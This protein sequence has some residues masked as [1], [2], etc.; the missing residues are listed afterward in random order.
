MED[1]GVDDARTQHGDADVVRQEVG[2]HGLRDAD[3]R[4]FRCGVDRHAGQGN[5]P[6][7]R[8]GVDEMPALAMGLDPVDEGHDAVDHTVVVDA[9][10]PVPVLVRHLVDGA[11]QDDARVVAHDVDV[12]EAFLRRVGRGH[13]S[14]AIGHVE[15]HGQEF[16]V[17]GLELA[18]HG[19]QGRLLD[20]GDHHLHAGVGERTRHGEPHAAC[21]AGDEC[22]LAG[23][24]A[25][26]CPLG[27]RVAAKPITV[28]A[29]RRCRCPDAT[30]PFA[31]LRSRRRLPRCRRANVRGHR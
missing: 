26:V 24:V 21:T 30:P 31:L 18:G 19:V 23:Y 16:G 13:E 2:A 9:R 20:V 29:P 6:G 10:D 8:G 25:H 7:H 28:D 27:S 11:A 3:H 12:A 1:I 4:V 17:P 22:G 15:R 5:V 14:V